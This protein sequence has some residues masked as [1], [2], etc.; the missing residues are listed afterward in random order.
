MPSP[1]SRDYAII[2]TDIHPSVDPERMPDFLPEPWKSRYR[3]GSR[4]PGVLGYWNPA[5][6]VRADSVTLDGDRIAMDPVL[7][8]KHFF[9]AYEVDYGIL[10]FEGAIHVGVG[11][12]PDYS[13]AVISAINDVAANYWLPVDPRFRA[14]L[15]V[16]PN[17]PILAAREI[18]RL[19]DHPGFVQVMMGSGAR[20]PY[21]QRYFHPIY[22]AAVAHDLPVAIHPGNEG[23]GITGPT[24]AVGYATSYLEWHTGLV[25]SYLGHLVSLITEGVFVK[26][27]TLKFVMVEGG[28]SWLPPI[29]WRL[30]KNWK[31]LRQTVPWL[32]KPPSEYI[33]EHVR[34]TTQPIE[35]PE[36]PTHLKQMLEMF[37]AGTMLMFSSDYP[38]WDGDT[39]SFSARPFGPDLRARVMGETA[40]ALY[41]LP[42][43]PVAR[44]AAA[45]EEVAVD[46]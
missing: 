32:E 43:E 19:G 11:A 29:M 17:D 36:N 4:G 10:N 22:E 13:S 27:P 5:G 1:R 45:I 39:P 23:V 2:D 9:D 26:F 34:L 46:D 3:S 21:G 44:S 16:A 6:V 31:G 25:A 12:E 41:R 7:L 30:D 33:R 42:A 20:I 14:S 24:S 28:V 18:H 40:R 15:N 37:D 35:E 38:H 8:G